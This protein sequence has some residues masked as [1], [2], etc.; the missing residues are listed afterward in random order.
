MQTTKQFFTLQPVQEALARLLNQL[1]HRIDTETIA[2]IDSLGRVLAEAPISPMDLPAFNRSAMDGY[3]VRAD[4]TFGA[5]DALPAYLTIAGHVAMGEVPEFTLQKGEVAEIHTGAMIPDGADAVVMIE[6]TQKISDSQLEV[7][8]P[9]S[10]GENIVKLGDDIQHGQET[11]AIGHTIRPQDIGGLLA[12]GIAEI[13]VFKRPKIGILS[14]GDE[15]ID[16]H[17]TPKIGQIRDINSH[18]IG[19]LCQQAGCDVELLGIASDTLDRLLSM[20]QQG[21]DTCDML[22]LSAGSSVSVRDL[23]SQVINQ[24]GQPG[25]IQHGIAVK[26]GKPT[27]LA[28][29]DGKPVI[30]LPGNPVSAML[31]ARQV[32]LPII[33]HSRHQAPKY[34]MTI[35]ATLTQNIDSTTGR[36]DS[37]PVKL[38]Q[39]DDGYKA[40]P[41]WG[42]SNL[43]YTLLQADGLVHVPLN[44]SGYTAGT[45]VEVI[46]F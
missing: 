24:L 41:I 32:V 12:V 20:A 5:S 37:V 40:T 4:D 23:T 26:P 43:I 27:I 8:S 1:E 11:L 9:V 17:E 46:G 3:A 6:H 2:T 29:C 14:S 45:Q 44:I 33:T 35:T 25:I 42:K 39:V 10:I 34:P 36:Y 7:L 18:I 21:Y 30:G 16:A 19:A 13:T 15:L 28:S 38:V 22:I 31:V